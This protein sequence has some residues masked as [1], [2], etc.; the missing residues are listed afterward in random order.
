MIPA[1]VD[2]GSVSEVL[3]AGIHDASLGEIKKRFATNARRTAL[4]EGFKKGVESLRTAGCRDIFLDG[5]FVTDKEFPGD[6]DAC[7]DPVGVVDTSLD[8][9]L[10][11]FTQ[12][13]RNQKLKYRGEFFPSSAQADGTRTFTEFF[14]TD[15]HTGRRKGI[16]RV[17]LS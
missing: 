11:D 3:P 10:L 1:F 8:P 13:R 9:I 7:W 14:Q 5:S 12:G 6:Y 2:I 16:I 17:R 15:R 4:Y